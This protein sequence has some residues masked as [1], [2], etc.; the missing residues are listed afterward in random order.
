MSVSLNDARNA[1]QLHLG[2]GI[3][4]KTEGTRVKGLVLFQWYSE[5]YS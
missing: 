2:P 1:A 4:Y 3:M 5:T